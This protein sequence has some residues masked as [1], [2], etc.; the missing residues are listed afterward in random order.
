MYKRQGEIVA[1]Q[2]DEIKTVGIVL[3]GR[4]SVWAYSIHG[5]ETWLGEFCEGQFIGM[6][7]F[8]SGAENLF[9]IR[10]ATKLTLRTT[11]YKNMRDLMHAETDLFE[12]VTRDISIRLNSALIDLVNVHSLSVKGRICVELLQMG[13]PMGCLLYTSPS[14]RD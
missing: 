12:A 13:R 11:S 5:D 14:P 10:A 3:S 2:S 1:F 6:S 7:S 4:A 9:E 8:F